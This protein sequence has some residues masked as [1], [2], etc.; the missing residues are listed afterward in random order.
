M[1]NR[2]REDTGISYID[3]ALEESSALPTD[4]ARA[5]RS[6][7]QKISEF[8]AGMRRTDVARRRRSVS[9]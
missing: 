7:Q 1:A 8:K 5:R 9:S 2:D 4:L 3:R 6:D